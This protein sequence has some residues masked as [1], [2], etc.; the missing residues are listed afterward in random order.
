[1][2]TST[3][4]RTPDVAIAVTDR[5]VAAALPDT[6]TAAVRGFDQLRQELGL[7]VNCC[8]TASYTINGALERLGYRSEVVAV[9]VN[10]SCPNVEDRR[11]MFAH[12]P[13]AAAAAVAARADLLLVLLVHRPPH[14]PARGHDRQLQEEEQVEHRP[15]HPGRDGTPAGARRKPSGAQ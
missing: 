15:P 4:Q 14:D 2:N 13:V 1:V 5:Q 12:D 9:E 7:P 3:K 10:V 6:F 11:R 8:I